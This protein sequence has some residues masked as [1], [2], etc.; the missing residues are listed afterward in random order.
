MLT[1]GDELQDASAVMHE[2]AR[3]VNFCLLARA[4][5]DTA[6]LNRAHAA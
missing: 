1:M 4:T 5:V 3:M 6:M 2:N